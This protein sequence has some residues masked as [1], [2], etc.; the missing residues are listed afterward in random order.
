MKRTQLTLRFALV[1]L[2]GSVLGLVGCRAVDAPEELQTLTAEVP[3]RPPAEMPG[4]VGSA[5]ATADAPDLDSFPLV[6]SV[7]PGLSGRL[8]SSLCD[9]SADP[10]S[11]CI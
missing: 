4:P 7:F 8:H 11:T 6:G 2:A 9:P 3:E 10:F 5:A 1:L